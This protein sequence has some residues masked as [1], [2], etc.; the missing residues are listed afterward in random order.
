MERNIMTH[1][2][3]IDYPRSVRANAEKEIGLFKMILEDIRCALHRDPAAR[4]W[5]EVLFN[6]A[7]LHAIW[8]YRI[9]HWLWTHKVYFLARWLSQAARWLT[10]V[11]IHPGAKIGRRVFIDHGMGVVIGETAEIGNEVTLY[12]G[13]TL[14]GVSLEKG[15]RHPTLGHNVVVGAGAKILG[16]IEIG[17]GSRIGANAVVVKPVPADSVVVGVPGQIVRRSHKDAE[18]PIDLHHDRLPDTLGDAMRQ[19]LARLDRLEDS[20][21]VEEDHRIETD[22][23]GNWIGSD[24]SI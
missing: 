20:L 18:E 23:N 14:G 6:Y 12:H 5:A 17:S 3:T 13:V 2:S 21:Q 8:T 9:S 1:T 24:F 11:E 15:K 4:N 7:G 22:E 10:G 16:D 19:V